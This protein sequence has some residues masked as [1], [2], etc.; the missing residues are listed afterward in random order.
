MRWDDPD[1]QPGLTPRRPRLLADSGANPPRRLWR[2]SLDRIARSGVLVLMI[3]SEMA[4][5]ARAQ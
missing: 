4:Q 3:H 2:R 1:D 5:T